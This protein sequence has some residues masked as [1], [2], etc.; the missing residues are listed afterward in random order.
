[1]PKVISI[2]RWRPLYEMASQLYELAPWRHMEEVEIFG[3]KDPVSRITGYVSIMGNIEEHTAMAVYLGPEGLSSFLDMQSLSRRVSTMDVLLVPQLQLSFEEREF[4]EE[5]DLQLIHELGFKARNRHGWP[6]FRSY[7]P[8]YA[9]W[10]FDNDE[11]ALFKTFLEQA[12]IVLKNDKQ[13]RDLLPI[14]EQDQILIRTP[15]KVKMDYVWKDARKPLRQCIEHDKVHAYYVESRLMLQA[16]FLPRRRQQLYVDCQLLITPIEERKG[17]RPYLPFILL[18]VDKASEMILHFDT[19]PGKEGWASIVSELPGRFVSAL[20]AIG[21][22]PT[23][24]L[25][26]SEKIY[27]LLKPLEK[28]LEFKL[29][30]IEDIPLIDQLIEDFYRHHGK[31]GNVVPM[32]F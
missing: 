4:L 21:C 14:L 3:V 12:L 24:I 29:K 5:D 31:D 11:I 17:E 30:L 9:P 18:V 2:S 6:F 28:G 27:D 20:A 23:S 1:M 15:R 25:L 16:K 8:G 32:E 10:F 26:R 19:F 13:R 22:R 7:R